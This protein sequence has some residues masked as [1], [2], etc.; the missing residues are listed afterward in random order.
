MQCYAVLEVVLSRW[1]IIR[2]IVR[3]AVAV[4]TRGITP[5]RLLFCIGL[6]LRISANNTA[7][8]T[9]SVGLKPNSAP[10]GDTLIS[11]SNDLSVRFDNP[12]HKK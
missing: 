12:T 10:F 5:L 7:I 8:T 9:A 4:H 11:R 6:A 1:K 3:T 2:R